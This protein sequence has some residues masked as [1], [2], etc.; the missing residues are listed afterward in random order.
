MSIDLEVQSDVLAVLVAANTG[1]AVYDNYAI[2]GDD[3]PYAVFG[4]V[5]LLQAHAKESRRNHVFF[6][7]HL[8]YKDGKGSVA[9]RTK[10]AEFRD[11]LDNAGLDCG[12]DVYFED[13]Q[14][15]YE[16]DEITTHVVL[17]FRAI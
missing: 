11:A 13:Q 10:A 4:D 8:F 15:L 16:Q 12:Y 7:I 14:V 17:N 9:A 3:F 5:Q 1:V 6:T 2:A